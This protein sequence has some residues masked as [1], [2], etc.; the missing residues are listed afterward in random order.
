MF[1]PISSSQDRATC[2]L[3][4]SRC[5]IVVAL[6]VLLAFICRLEAVV[7]DELKVV[8][9]Q[10]FFV[11][12]QQIGG[13]SGLSLATAADFRSVDFWSKVREIVQQRPVSVN[14]ID[15]SYIV[16]SDEK[17]RMPT[18]L[19][20]D[21]GHPHHP[22]TLQGVSK[23]GVVFR[24]LPTDSLEG[25]TGPGF[26]VISH[27]QNLVLR[28]LHFTAEQPIT[29]AT[30]FANVQQM[31]FEGCSWTDLPRVKLGATGT[32]ESSTDHVTYANCVFKR[33]GT[34]GG[35]HMSYNA[36]GPKHV[37]FIN[38][39]FEDCSGDYVRYRAGADFGVVL[40]CTFKSTGKWRGVNMPF[41]TV[42]QANDDDPLKKGSAGGYEYFGSHFLVANNTFEYANETAK[43]ERIAL[44]FHHSGFDP[45]GRS[46]LL[47]SE[48]GQLLAN[49]SV[50][51]R[52]AL[53]LS[54][55]GI[56]ANHVHFFNNRFVGV[57]K[58]VAYR[59]Y[60]AYGAK[61]KGWKGVADI[62]ELINV[63]PVPVDATKALR[64]F[65]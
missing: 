1:R 11:A 52:R 47:T 38:C 56:D 43:G 31:L 14:F 64:F 32:S 10:A 53:M 49:G 7:G 36:Y 25:E 29:Y 35:A 50:T 45:P 33:V 65:K 23:S 41:I 44:L 13:G 18:L 37:N 62:T 9:D 63:S 27:S 16:S 12:P 60:A 55:F 51:A 57:D 42:P 24:R 15:G 21:L 20:A 2:A 17:N 26:L 40:G 59:S 46:H 28:N 54:N 30:S 22:L 19:L 4:R 61:S 34:G 6:L 39:H 58:K 8:T 48:Q 3:I 5:K